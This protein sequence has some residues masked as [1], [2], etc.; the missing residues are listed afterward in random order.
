[1]KRIEVKEDRYAYAVYL[2]EDGLFKCPHEDIEIEY[3][4]GGDGYTEPG[5]SWSVYCNDCFND[6][7]EQHEVNSILEGYF[8]NER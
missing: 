4:R 7:M 8:D 2:N 3:D 6:D 1:M 5:P